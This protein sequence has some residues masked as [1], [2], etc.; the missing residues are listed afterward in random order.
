MRPSSCNIGS[1]YK[2]WSLVWVGA[3]GASC[4]QVVV[5]TPREPLLDKAGL[6]LV[7][8]CGVTHGNSRGAEQLSLTFK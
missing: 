2:L 6:E 8:F 4:A 7:V 5:S 1:S 3:E